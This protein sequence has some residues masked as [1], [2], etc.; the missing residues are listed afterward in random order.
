M[1]MVIYQNYVSH[2]MKVVYN[3]WTALYN[4]LHK[5]AIVAAIQHV[6]LRGYIAS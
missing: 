5:Q 6:L 2:I 1:N 3:I 4:M